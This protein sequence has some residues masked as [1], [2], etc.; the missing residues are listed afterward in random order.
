MKLR[1]RRKEEEGPAFRALLPPSQAALRTPLPFLLLFSFPL[2]ISALLFLHP[3]PPTYLLRRPN[4]SA[5]TCRQAVAPAILTPVVLFF[6]FFFIKLQKQQSRS[7]AVAAWHG[8]QLA[9][10]AN[11][12]SRSGR[13]ARRTFALHQIR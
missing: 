11:R 13:P 10:P 5:A 6:P 1:S 8:P 2:I 3:A 7:V 9:D 4:L 12:S